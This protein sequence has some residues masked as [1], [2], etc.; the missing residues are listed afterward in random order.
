MKRHLQHHEDKIHELC[1]ERLNEQNE[2][3]KAFEEEKI[4]TIN[5]EALL[6]IENKKNEELIKKME[7]FENLKNLTAQL[8]ESL[9]QAE[10][11]KFLIFF[12]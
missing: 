1:E 10:V 6:D 7:D 4:K 8:Q 12:F 11:S 3:K 9:K 2:N 5:L